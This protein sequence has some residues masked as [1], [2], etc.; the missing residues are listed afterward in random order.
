MRSIS[1]YTLLIPIVFITACEEAYE[2]SGKSERAR[3]AITSDP[4]AIHPVLYRTINAQ[5]IN[6]LVF[7][8]LMQ[9]DPAT[10][11]PVPVLAS[12]PPTISPYQDSL[13]RITYNIKSK[14]VWTDE[15][16]VTADD[17][18]FT[19]KAT[20]M[21]G[22]RAEGKRDFL[23]GIRSIYADTLNEKR[24]HFVC[25]H[26]LR[27][28]YAT[29]AELG[30][31]P[32]H[33]Y[34]ADGLI[35]NVSFSDI[36]NY[37]SNEALPEN[38]Q[39]FAETFNDSKFSR[40]PDFVHGSGPYQLTSWTSGQSLLLT[41]KENWWGKK[42]EKT[43]CYFQNY[44]IEIKY[45]IIAEPTAIIKAAKNDQIDVGPILRSQDYYDLQDNDIFLKSFKLAS[46]PELSTNIILMNGCKPILAD[47]KVRKALAHLFDVQTYIKVV[48]KGS[49]TEVTGPLHNT[50]PGY[51]DGIKPYPFDAEIA[52]RLLEDAGWTDSDGDGIRDKM[53]DGV[54]TNLVLEYLYHTGHE[55]RRNAGMMLQD[56]ARAA[57]VKIE[58][59]NDEW[60]VFIERLM[61]GD[62]ELAFFSWTDEHAPTDP[63]PV[64]HSSAIENGYNFNCYSS[65][66]ADSL[67]E[68]IA[69]AQ[70]QQQYQE[71][72]KKLQEV[73][74]RDV[75]N[76]FLS[77][78]QSKI[79][80]SRRFSGFA[81]M[82]IPPGY[83]AGSLKPAQ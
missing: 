66:V 14:A 25:E 80:V 71:N 10:H 54:K 68:A 63:T 29:G 32:A 31:L 9:T 47:V 67:I 15:T 36:I 44:P 5:S 30:I 23:R 3:I 34:D 28:T 27:T 62:F 33:L 65:T 70:N 77:T 50:K 35:E 74:H 64:Y 11:E 1:L 72:W 48:Q 4:D 13:I 79:F 26:N 73:L 49:G 51:H 18:I 59:R 45:F 40:D 24:V 76:I 60:L 56:W 22:V 8:K 41:R 7:Q 53:I 52:S 55:G 43:L 12:A 20:M 69:Q 2:T 58:V 81:P 16:P 61:A 42:T 78:N 82:A 17:V 57:G 83:F 75:P 39:L 37:N 6:D 38:W 46:T 21:P 19:F